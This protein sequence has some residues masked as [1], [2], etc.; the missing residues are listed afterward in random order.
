MNIKRGG[1]PLTS[2]SLKEH[3]S[4]ISASPDS[5][6]NSQPK[7]DSVKSQKGGPTSN[8]NF[9]ESTYFNIFSTFKW[10][11]ILIQSEVDSVRYI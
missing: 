4:L 8:F 7:V 3:H 5:S 9:S 10:Q 1:P 6:W 2:I 11:A